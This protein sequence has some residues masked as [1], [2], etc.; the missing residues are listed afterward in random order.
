M[1]TKQ[2]KTKTNE[3]RHLALSS[4]EKNLSTYNI[5]VSRFFSS[6]PS[7]IPL[8]LRL[9]TKILW[10]MIMEELIDIYT[11]DG[12]RIGTTTKKEYYS[13]N[14][15]DVPWIKCCS[16]FV[17]DEN[18]KKILFEKRGKRFL[19]PGKLDLCSG[20]VQAGETPTQSMVRELNEELSIGENDSRNVHFLGTLKIDYTNLKDETN[21]KLLKCFVSAY[22]L[23]MKDIGAIKI[24]NREAISMGWLNLEDTIGFISNNMTRIP[25][26][27]NLKK[28][29]NELFKNLEQYMYPKSINNKDSIKEQ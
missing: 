28:S 6:F 26:D 13:G 29:Y 27:E 15:S 4:V 21:R 3:K 12:K 19:D 14:T 11:E 10:V 2:I 22:A 20:H 16:C 7:N 18:E 1:L 5:I 8:L 9:R 17:I 24:D 23:K 25:Y